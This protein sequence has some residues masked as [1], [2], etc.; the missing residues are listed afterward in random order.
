MNILYQ[1]GIKRTLAR[2]TSFQT[3]DS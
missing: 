1:Y 2:V 3:E